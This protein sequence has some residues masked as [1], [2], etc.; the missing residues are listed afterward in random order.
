MAGVDNDLAT[1]ARVGELL[2]LTPNRPRVI[3][4]YPS[5]R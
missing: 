2:E 5:T 1:P 3:P 4:P